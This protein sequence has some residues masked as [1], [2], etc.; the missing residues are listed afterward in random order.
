AFTIP[1]LSHDI[2]LQFIIPCEKLS[3]S[4]AYP[5]WWKIQVKKIAK[6]SIPHYQVKQDPENRKTTITY[7]ANNVPALQIEKYSPFFKEVVNYFEF[8]ITDLQM[9]S[10]S[11]KSE[12]SWNDLMISLRKDKMNKDG[13]LSS[14]VEN[15]TKDIIKDVHTPLEKLDTI[16]TYLQTNIEPMN[17]YDDRNF[18]RILEDKKGSVSRITGLAHSMLT[19]AGLEAQ[20]LLLHSAKDG[21]FDRDYISYSQ[22]TIPAVGV[23]IE[24]EKYVVFPYAKIPIS[25]VPQNFQGQLA[26]G[27]SGDKQSTEVEFWEVP[28][29]N[30]AENIVDEEYNLKIDEAGLINVSEIKT[31]RGSN[32][33][34]GRQ[35]LEDLTDD[36]LEDELKELLTY[37]DGEI[38]IVSRE[39]INLE[40]YKK[41][42][43]IKLNYTIDNLITLTPEEVIFQTGGLFSPISGAKYKIDTEERQ[44]PIRIYYNE[45]IIKHINI[46]FP[47]SWKI[48]KPLKNIEFQNI[49]GRIYGEYHISSGQLIANQQRQLV[50]S[51]APKEKISELLELTGEK[52]RLA[53]PTIVFRIQIPNEKTN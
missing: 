3:F 42:L 43:I 32:A 6:D 14:L 46:S 29:G 30:Q 51:D 25:Y 47:E 37:T 40:A 27:I 13:F 23:T 18:K 39:I 5:D 1:P 33:Y 9:L 41:P 22:F 2:P 8:M 10:R 15:T 24:D 36:E 35:A 11:Y 38:K 44:N 12:K 26:L 45:T 7:L 17:E 34:F 49:F 19:K 4:Y 52:S 48:E 20:Y 50:R 31:Y 28:S 16:I 53:I 21:Y